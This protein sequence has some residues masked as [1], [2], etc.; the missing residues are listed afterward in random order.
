MSLYEIIVAGIA[1]S[2]FVLTLAVMA[3]N[4]NKAAAAKLD[5]LG[6]KLEAD[7]AEMDSRFDRRAV[8]HALRIERLDAEAES[9]EARGLG[10]D[11]RPA[12]R[13]PAAGG[14]LVRRDVRSAGADQHQHAAA[15]EP[16][17]E[18]P[19]RPRC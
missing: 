13:H 16:D 15:L 14:A 6:R 5:E 12:Q 19:V 9:A 11:L 3:T 1:A 17:D 7:L 4:R 10:L 8:E 18:D 2:N